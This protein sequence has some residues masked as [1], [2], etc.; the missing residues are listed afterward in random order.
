MFNF[1]KR[2]KVGLGNEEDRHQWVKETLAKIP[3]GKKLLDAGAGECQYRKH[4]GHLE[5]TSQDFSQYD[6][7]GDIGAHTGTWDTSQIDIVSDIISIPVPGASFDVVLC[8]E[9][10]EHVPYPL[11]ALEEL[12]R[13]LKPGGQ[14]I[15]TAPFISFTHFAPYHYHTGFSRFFYEHH[16]PAM[17]LQITEISP[18]GNF[19]ELTAQEVRRIK[20]AAKNYAGK[21]YNWFDRIFVH[22]LLISLNRFSRADQKSSELACY[23]FHVIASKK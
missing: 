3:A 14:L 9:V 7:T 20:W 8:T 1:N 23:G 12:A 22:L 21:K 17:G 11:K 6:G 2:F 5:Y 15:V 4:C 19:F 16:L 10:L 13:V 18:N